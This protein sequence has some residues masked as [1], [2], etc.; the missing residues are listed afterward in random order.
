VNARTEPTVT[1]LLRSV[2]HPEGPWLEFQDVQEIPEY[3]DLWVAQQVI[4]TR[5]E[6]TEM[7]LRVPLT[8]DV[9]E[10]Y[11]VITRVSAPRPSAT[12]LPYRVTF[13]NIHYVT[14]RGENPEVQVEL[15][16]EHVI[17]VTDL[18]VEELGLAAFELYPTLGNAAES[19]EGSWWITYVTLPDGKDVSVSE[20]VWHANQ[21]T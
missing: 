13:G 12:A 19:G 1:T 14:P 16:S 15:W 10:R 17:P 8:D 20:L 18:D 3:E 21:N 9:T 11:D 4:V 7:T 6:G 5:I 2:T